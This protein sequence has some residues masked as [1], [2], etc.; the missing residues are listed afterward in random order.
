MRIAIDC[1]YIGKSGIGTFLENILKELLENHKENK[2]LLIINPNQ[3]ICWGNGFQLLI[4]KTDPFTIQDMLFFPTSEVNKCDVFFTPYISVP[5]RVKIPVF[6]TIH[7]MLFMDRRELTSWIGYQIR[8]LFMFYTIR[9]STKIFTVSEFSKKR[10]NFHFHTSKDIIVTYNDINNWIK[11]KAKQ[12]DVV[13]TKDSYLLYVG[14]IKRHKGLNILL[15][16]YKKAQ[17]NGFGMKLLVVGSADNFRTKDHEILNY[18][19]SNPNIIFTGYVSNDK[20]YN[21]I[22]RASCLVLPS[23]YEGFGITPLEALYIGTN[24]ILTDIEVLKEIYSS[25]PVTFFKV[26]DEEDLCNK[27]LSFNFQLLNIN[28]IRKKIDYCFGSSKMCDIILSTLR[29]V[30]E[31]S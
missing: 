8:K 4:V 16:S 7:D 19:N 13:E 29:G 28:E 5:L 23:F 25:F 6:V 12:D 14:N 31:N 15:S 3:N 30:N 24:V 17:E 10:I 22:K 2:Y 26:G 27:L 21:Y 20:L 11:E 18:I 1:R 9:K